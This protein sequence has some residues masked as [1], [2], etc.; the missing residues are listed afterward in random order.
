MRLLDTDCC[1]NGA[2]YNSGCDGDDASCGLLSWRSGRITS[3]PLI[4]QRPKKRVRFSSPPFIEEQD[5]DSSSTCD[6]NDVVNEVSAA[7]ARTDT[8]SQQPSSSKQD[9][10]SSHSSQAPVAVEDETMVMDPR[11][12]RKELW[13]T[14][15]ERSQI[16]DECRNIGREYKEAHSETVQEYLDLYED[17]C[18]N[19]GAQSIPTKDGTSH[20][21]S[22]MAFLPLF[23]THVRGLEWCVVPSTR[24]HR[25][26]HVHD[27]LDKQLELQRV[28]RDMRSK[29]LAR[30]SIQ[31][32][33]PS[34]LL[35]RYA[36]QM[37]SVAA[38]TATVEATVQ[39][40]HP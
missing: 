32:S 11:E 29:I 28:G 23:P 7:T 12:R 24:S 33:K 14:K 10:S 38:A 36:G 34:R 35:A 26:T 21:L 16:L 3:S 40:P 6:L 30:R 5:Q 20:D 2:M 9:S 8:T 31:S 27:I 25:K 15:E 18:C 13:W 22:M 37:D 39:A 4:P 17:E 19:G 1:S